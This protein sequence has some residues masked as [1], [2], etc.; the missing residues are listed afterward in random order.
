MRSEL[1]KL[2]TGT[3]ASMR[4]IS[5]A[6]LFG[7]KL[8]IAPIDKQREFAEHVEQIQAIESQ[9]STA[10]QKAEGVFGA[11]LAGAFNR[12]KTDLGK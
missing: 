11:L 5:R 9:Q 3:S 1:G 10:T 2:S 12:S 8:P 4:N 6:K 7:L